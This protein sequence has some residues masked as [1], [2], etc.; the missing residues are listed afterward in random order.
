MLKQL[1][2]TT[3]I[4]ELTEG[5]CRDYLSEA[6]EK[7]NFSDNEINL[8][9][10]QILAIVVFGSSKKYCDYSER[11]IIWE[12]QNSE[13]FNDFDIAIIFNGLILDFNNMHLELKNNIVFEY[14]D[15]Y[16]YSSIKKY[17]K[18][19]Q[20]FHFSLFKDKQFR[21]QLLKKDKHAISITKGKRLYVKDLKMTK[22]LFYVKGKEK[23]A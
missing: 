18:Q 6:L 9:D 19:A 10:E 14:I 4:K 5:N 7:A 16:G 11:R 12:Y 17:P 1:G 23:C 3:I 2:R 21:Q 15:S 13:Q 20:Y 8:I 22:E